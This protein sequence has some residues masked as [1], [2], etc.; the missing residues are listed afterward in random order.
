MTSEKFSSSPVLETLN[1]HV[2]IREYLDKPIPDNLLTDMLH[3]ARR[4]PTSSNLQAYSFVV[5]RDSDTKKKLA[6]FAGNQKHIETCGVFVAICADISRL[7]KACVLHGNNLG[8]NLENTMVATI[9]A[10][11]AGMSLSTIAESFGL[12]TVMIGGMRNQ[13]KEVAE[14]LNFPIGVIVAFGLCIGWPDWDRVH[15]Q[16]PR[17]DPDIN[18]HYEQYESTGVQEKLLEYDQKLANHYQTEGR[19]TQDAAWTGIIASRF[20]TPRRPHLKTT[21]EELGFS[22][23]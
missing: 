20:N 18:I 17:F 9:D 16:K 22:F 12:G 10:A 1:N 6:K 19:Q 8:K 14:L 15:K 21:M 5:V 3:A 4:S 2:S 11:L 13:P 7:E 23:D